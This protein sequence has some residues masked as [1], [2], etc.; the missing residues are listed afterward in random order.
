MSMWMIGSRPA[1]GLV[2]FVDAEDSGEGLVVV[3]VD[4]G[5]NLPAAVVGDGEDDLDVAR[6]AALPRRPL[7][8]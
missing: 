7:L 6:D 4:G 8:Y 5:A 1:D 3:E 2:D